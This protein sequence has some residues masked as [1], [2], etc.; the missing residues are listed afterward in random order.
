MPDRA[1]LGRRF[2]AQAVI[3]RDGK[4]A[5]PLGQG[6]APAGG[7]PH[8][9]KRIRAAG[10]GQ[11]DC[12]GA[13]EVREEVFCILRGNRGIVVVRHDAGYYAR[14][15]FARPYAALVLI[16]LAPKTGLPATPRRKPE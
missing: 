12:G 6:V 2:R 7:K 13:F 16:G 9:C 3:D 8:Q 1:C 10:N 15:M 14:G 11:D 4:K 5:R